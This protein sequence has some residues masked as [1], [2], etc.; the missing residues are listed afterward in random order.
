MAEDRERT[1]IG[2]GDGYLDT[3]RVQQ[4]KQLLLS[5]DTGHAVCQ[6]IFLMSGNL[7]RALTM[8]TNQ[9][10]GRWWPRQFMR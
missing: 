1:Q 8:M 4:T 10:Q 6:A 2:R 5:L 9:Y 3:P 7:H